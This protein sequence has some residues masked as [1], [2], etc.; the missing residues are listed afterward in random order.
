MSFFYPNILDIKSSSHTRDKSLFGAYPK[1][2]YGG[3][4][5]KT[6]IKKGL[7]KSV[8]NGTAKGVNN[9][10]RQFDFDRLEK[11]H[12]RR[13]ELQGLVEEFLAAKGLELSNPDQYANEE[14][15]STYAYPTEYKGLKPIEEQI[16][17]I[18]KI[19]GLDPTVAL[20]LAKSLPNLPKGAEGNAAW[21]SVDILGKKYFP[22]VQSAEEK[23]CAVANL[24]LDKIGSSRSFYNYRKGELTANRF[25]VIARTANTIAQIEKAQKS[26]IL[27]APVQLGMLHRGRSVRRAREVFTPNEFGLETVIAGSIVLVHPERLVR[28]EELDMDLAGNEFAPDADGEFSH[29]AYLYFRVD[30]AKFGARGVDGPSDDCGAASGFFSQS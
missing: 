12:E 15:K 23:Y 8:G 26:E 22:K 24:V 14:V 6:E 2:P 5:N 7:R 29:A 13:N 11:L 28:F 16:M 20:K 21:P 19:Y 27:I 17:A 25:R 18:A 30:K 10:F 1:A 4:M 3:T 9:L